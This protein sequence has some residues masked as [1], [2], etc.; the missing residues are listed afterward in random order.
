MTMIHHKEQQG[1]K[2][3]LTIFIIIHL[4]FAAYAGTHANPW[5]ATPFL[6]ALAALP[7][8]IH[9]LL[10][11]KVLQQESE[12]QYQLKSEHSENDL[13]FDEAY[14]VIIVKRQITILNKYILPCAAILAV[15]SFLSFSYLHLFDPWQWGKLP[16]KNGF[17]HIAFLTFLSAVTFVSSRFLMGASTSSPLATH[18]KNIG[19]LLFYN[20]ITLSL[21]TTLFILN[22]GLLH[23]LSPIITIALAV[24]T[25]TYPLEL[26][27]NILNHFYGQQPSILGPLG[28]R[29]AHFSLHSKLKDRTS[30][31]LQYQFGYDLSSN[32]KKILNQ[33]G[34]IVAW[35]AIG[36]YTLSDSIVTIPTGHEG[37]IS[38]WGNI[39]KDSLLPGLHFKWPNPIQKCHIISKRQEQIITLGKSDEDEAHTWDSSQHENDL[40]MILKS[41][42]EN[43]D[44]LPIEI[45]SISAIL[46]YHINSPKDWMSHHISPRETIYHLAFNKLTHIFLKK[47]RR[48]LYET[49]RNEIEERLREQLQQSCKSLNLGIQVLSFSI[50]QIHPPTETLESFQE[51]VKAQFERETMVTSAHSQ[52]E[53]L[54]LK[55]KS[56][57]NVELHRAK[58]KSD[59][60]TAKVKGLTNY[61]NHLLVFKDKEKDIFWQRKKIEALPDALESMHKIIVLSKHKDVLQTIDLQQDLNPELLDLNLEA[62]SL[63]P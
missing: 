44:Q 57:R 40:Q 10:L 7:F 23:F 31:T 45:V 26:P 2:W 32:V 3:S 35:V 46:R 43:Q 61:M 14:E 6:L 39:K 13:I 8:W 50:P 38:E 62:R 22:S 51:A 28:T 1:L 30:E 24:T 18:S 34:I 25:L 11:G 48:E 59:A 16:Q 27:F 47:N 29:L 52:A 63:N 49:S 42:L 4:A 54:L 15:I 17:A 41:P 60:I 37:V 33:H 19:G 55:S 58:A 36:C 12:L 56:Q 21:F 20:T 5:L 53:Q 9:A